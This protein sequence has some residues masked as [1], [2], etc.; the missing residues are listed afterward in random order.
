IAFHIADEIKDVNRNV[1][2]VLINEITKKGVTEA[3]AHP[4]TLNANMYDAQQARRILDRIVGYKV[5]P[6]LWNKVKRGLSAGRVQSEAGRASG[7]EGTRAGGSPG[8]PRPTGRQGGG[9]GSRRSFP[10]GTATSSS[11]ARRPRPATS[12]GRSSAPAS[13]STRSSA[14]SGGATRRRR[15]S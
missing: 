2:R 11:S 14:R 10:A 4:T 12:G 8:G 3:L 9:R 15:S 7:G 6:V 1:Q 5:S 13:S